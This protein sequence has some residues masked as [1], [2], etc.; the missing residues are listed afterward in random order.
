MAVNDIFLRPGE[1]N[2]NDIVLRDPTVA[3]SGASHQIEPVGVVSAGAFG[4]VGLNGQIG[5]VGVASAEAVGTVG[6]H[7]T[8]GAVGIASAVGIG[9][10]QLNG[11]LAA[12]GIHSSGSVGAP[13][14]N[15]TL[16]AVGISSAEGI[17]TLALH[18]SVAPSGIAGTGAIGTPALQG[19]IAP[20]GLAGSSAF[21]SP[22]VGVL[23]VV[24]IAS[25]VAVGQATV[26]DSDIP[27]TTDTSGA[28]FARRPRYPLSLLP[29]AVPPALFLPDGIESA[30]RVGVPSID[31]DEAGKLERL[32]AESLMLLAA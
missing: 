16:A 14:V 18:G 27:A 8:I 6:L 3:D 19:S 20:A 32:N 22:R 23:R 17:G 12:V 24:G 30:A 13:G 5:A 15:G 2:P 29:R 7:G 4:V 26:V 25:A 21:G 10:P 1:A 28:G 9:A 31:T 11:T